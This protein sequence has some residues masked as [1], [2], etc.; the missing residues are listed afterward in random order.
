MRKIVLYTAA[1]LD[2]FIA[3]ENG[4]IDWLFN[5]SEGQDY[6]YSEF[7]KSVDTVIMGGATFRQVDSFEGDFPY[8]DKRCF[9]FSRDVS[10]T[11]EYA[12]FI[13]HDIIEHVKEWKEEKSN[14]NIWL[15]GGGSINTLLL[16]AQLIDELQLFVHPII[17]SKGIR[18]FD[19]V[20]MDSW[21]ELSDLEE[22][23]DGMLRLVYRKK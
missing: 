5:G 3:R 4:D 23:G 11:H 9:V 20:N 2:G 21:F 22:F 7:T 8:A 16:E 12:K 15:V 14:K 13:H 17:L 18:M 10:L 19:E 1:S 6:G